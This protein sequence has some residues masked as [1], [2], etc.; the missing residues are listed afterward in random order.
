MCSLKFYF[1]VIIISIIQIQPILLIALKDSDVFIGHLQ[2]IP[3]W[4]RNKISF[5]SDDIHTI[6]SLINSDNI[7]KYPQLDEKLNS[8]TTAINCIYSYVIQLIAMNLKQF[9]T[10][11]TNPYQGKPFKGLERSKSI[12]FGDSKLLL[13]VDE[14]SATPIKEITRQKS[15]DLSDLEEFYRTDTVS[16]LAHQLEPNKEYI[17]NIFKKQDLTYQILDGYEEYVA[18]YRDAI[19]RMIS[20][21]IF[22]Q[23]SP[24]NWMWKYFLSLNALE[25][26]KLDFEEFYEYS[27]ESLIFCNKYV[28]S[29]RKS[30]YLHNLEPNIV[31]SLKD[32]KKS[33]EI[34]IDLLKKMKLKPGDNNE[35]LSLFKYEN[36]LGVYDFLFNKKVTCFI[37]FYPHIDNINFK[38]IIRKLQANYKSAIIE[39]KRNPYLILNYYNV[40]SDVMKIALLYYSARHLINYLILV[41]SKSK[42]PTE[43][44]ITEKELQDKL[45]LYYTRPSKIIKTIIRYAGI[46]GIPIYSQIAKVF[47]DEK[48][49]DKKS[50]K[51]LINILF[52]K[53]EELLKSYG[54][55]NENLYK[56][57]KKG[58]R[59]LNIYDDIKNE[60]YESL[61]QYYNKYRNTLGAI[62]FDII[63]FFQWSK[64]IKWL[65]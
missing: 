27:E 20:V 60:C 35:L 42:K 46:S 30:N 19:A 56:I 23:Q 58:D 43:I 59:T 18:I 13:Y 25:K 39:W 36:N 57:S 63:T 34:S 62:N 8:K 17:I 9:P 10:I 44:P 11:V 64:N 21:V 53:L 28:A 49:K 26:R 14:E 65:N 45:S 29:C 47:D 54:A 37:T 52:K 48:G 7:Q 6:A 5:S 40:L 50:A 51:A 2:K 38:P 22:S 1:F 61:L 15:E 33:V 55:Y 3:T 12:T 32:L 4:E 16:S 31:D 24:A 41:K